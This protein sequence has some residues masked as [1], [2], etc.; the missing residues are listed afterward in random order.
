MFEKRVVLSRDVLCTKQSHE[1]ATFRSM[2]LTLQETGIEPV[3]P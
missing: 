2:T 1:A 3:A